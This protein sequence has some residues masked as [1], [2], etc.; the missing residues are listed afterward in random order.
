MAKTTP[1][2]PVLAVILLIFA[3]VWIFNELGYF[4]INVPW[5]P[6]I[7]AIITIGM[8]SNRYNR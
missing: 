6:V 8:I 5:I 3:I 2:F 1:K 7:L 4:S